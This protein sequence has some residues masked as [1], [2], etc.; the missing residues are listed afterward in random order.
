MSRTSL[1]IRKQ[2]NVRLPPTLI[3]DIDQA[4]GPI[5]RDRWIERAAVAALHPL[6]TAQDQ[7]LRQKVHQHRYTDR[8]GTKWTLGMKMVTMRCECGQETDTQA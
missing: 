1:G 4:R 6:A 2:M 3:S 5:S 7:E 8:A